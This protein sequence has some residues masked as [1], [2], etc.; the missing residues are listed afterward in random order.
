MKL[1]HSSVVAIFLVSTQLHWIIFPVYDTNRR[2][3]ILLAR[4][5]GNDRPPVVI[6][7]VQNSESRRIIARH[8]LSKVQMRGRVHTN[9]SEGSKLRRHEISLPSDSE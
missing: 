5:V 8:I 9:H 3:V 1:P 7:D 2:G 4:V 6:Y